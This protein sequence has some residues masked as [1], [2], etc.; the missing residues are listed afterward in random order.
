MQ[1]YLSEVYVII[2]TSPMHN[3]SDTIL[4]IGKVKASGYFQ[5]QI[6][7]ANLHILKYC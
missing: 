1:K 4:E 2:D 5:M 6:F 7:A 3:A